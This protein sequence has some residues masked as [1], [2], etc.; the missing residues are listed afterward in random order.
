MSLNDLYQK[1]ILEHYKNPRHYGTIEN[2]QISACEENPVC[3]DQIQLM[4]VVNCR[5]G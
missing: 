1:I 5:K 4:M 3:G 2:C